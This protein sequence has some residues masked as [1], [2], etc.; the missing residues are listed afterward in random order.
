MERLSNSA[1]ELNTATRFG[2]FDV[3]LSLV[4]RKVQPEFVRRHAGW[5]KKLRIVDLEVQGVRMTSPG[6]AEVQLE[7]SWHRLDQTTIRV[8]QVAQR[9]KQGENAWLLAE[10]RRSG[11][12]AG[13][14]GKRRK[15]KSD[16]ASPED[17][18]TTKSTDSES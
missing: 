16:H 11:G 1:Y 2:R 7:V 5:G 18:D 4:E 13:I 6:Q 14:F 3:A 9:W 17:K 8:S 10:E 15:R 12:D